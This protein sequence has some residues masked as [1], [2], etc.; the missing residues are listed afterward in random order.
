MDHRDAVAQRVE[1]RGELDLLALQ[2]EG[3]GIGRVD[4]GDDFH[5]RRLA[6]AVLAHQRVDMAALQ[7]ERHVVEREH[8]G[9][10]FADVGDFEQI[11]GARNGA[12]LPDDF[13]GRR[14]DGRHGAPSRICRCRAAL[15]RGRAM[16]STKRGER[17]EARV[18]SPASGA[19]PSRQGERA[20]R[21]AVSCRSVLLHE[22]VHVGRGHELEGNV[23]LLVDRSCP[24]RAPAPRRPRPCPG[25]RRP[26]TR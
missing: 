9:K 13:G 11:F 16:P 6:G 3:A 18:R 20:G 17:P 19:P 23:D 14:T 25:R 24:R 21:R 8:A 7:A 1:R 10:G 4:A 5:Q 26:G 2:P 22:L 12:A 15:V